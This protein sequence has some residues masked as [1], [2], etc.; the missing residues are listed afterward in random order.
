MENEIWKSIIGYEGFYEVSNLGK[1][2]SVDRIVHC[3]DGRS[4]TQKGKII[5]THLSGPKEYK[6]YIYVQLSKNGERKNHSVH[7]LVATAFIPNPDNLSEINHKDEKGWNNVVE[8]LE[9]CDRTYQMRYGT[10]KERVAKKIEKPVLQIKNGKVIKRFCSVEQAA[11]E[12]G[13][14]STNIS[15]VCKGGKYRKT[16]GGFNWEYAE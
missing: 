8:N 14:N 4:F 13:V 6:N 9:W 1:I 5:K 11:I 16:A 12:T 15:R 2:R 10:I 3:S 7:R